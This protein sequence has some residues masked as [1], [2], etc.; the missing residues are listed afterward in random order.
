MSSSHKISKKKI[1]LGTVIGLFLL[2][3]VISVISSILNT[4]EIAGTKY[5]TNDS[6]FTIRDYAFTADDMEALAKMDSL[7]YLSFTNCT[8]P[9]SDLSWIRN[10]STLSLENC[11]LT[12]QHISSIDFTSLDLNALDLDQNP[13]VTDLSSVSNLSA[14][15]TTLSFRGCNVGDISFLTSLTKLTSLYADENSIEEI[16]F[17][18]NCKN[19]QILSLKSNKLTSLNG[20]ENCSNLTYLD[21]S[22][23]SISNI[24]LPEG[25]FKFLDLS[26]NTCVKAIDFSNT[27]GDKVI[28]DYITSVDYSSLI[29][30]SYGE[31]VIIDCP[32]DKQKTFLSMLG[33]QK[34]SFLSE[35]EYIESYD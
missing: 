17:V 26:G 20:I 2:M 29:S 16:S 24:A 35:T 3:V 31:Y 4:V 13:M 23:N 5:K 32:V 11:G 25:K 9:D 14:T 15:L 19:L 7:N 30:C 28:F 18:S 12:D 8:L 22:N 21:L 1:F 6:T 34:I 33:D 10:V 27:T